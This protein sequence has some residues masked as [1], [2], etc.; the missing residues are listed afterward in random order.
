MT[1]VVFLHSLPTRTNPGLQASTF[2]SDLTTDVVEVV[3][4]PVVEVVV[5]V[6]EEV[7]VEE[8][9]VEVEVLEVKED[10]LTQT[11]PS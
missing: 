1:Q 8:V 6:V 9:L 7:V 3:E 10:L 5:V 11:V 2:S 4:D